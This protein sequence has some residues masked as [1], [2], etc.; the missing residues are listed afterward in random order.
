MQR[1]QQGPV[2]IYLRGY[3]EYGAS[4]TVAQQ[5]ETFMPSVQFNIYPVMICHVLRY[6]VTF[7]M[8]F[9]STTAH[10]SNR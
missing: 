5:R 6:F 8:H 1:S 3:Y 10:K 9:T 4:L 2:P 7:F